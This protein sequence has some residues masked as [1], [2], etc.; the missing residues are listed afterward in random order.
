MVGA[1]THAPFYFQMPSFAESVGLL[2]SLLIYYGHPLR[3]RR[4]LHLYRPFVQAG[5]LVFDLG[6]H[7]GNHSRAFLAMGANV[8]A[9]EPQPLFARFLL[10]RFTRNPRFTLNRCAIGDAEGYVDLFLSSR[11]PTVSTATQEW[12]KEVESTQSF[13]TVRWDK[14]LSVQQRTLDSLIEEHGE[15]AFIKIDVEGGESGVLNGLSRSVHALCFEIVPPGKDNGLRCVDRL[16]ILGNY[17]F[18]WSS[19]E[20]SRL[21][22]EWCGLEEIE[23]RIR[24]LQPSDREV[25]IYARRV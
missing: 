7:V 10:R 16:N 8:L 11:T 21:Q 9:I 6:A 13:S 18:N 4:L 23:A 5:D 15:P 20:L 17:N 12:I 25:N 24:A 3:H 22:P 19:G 2:R 14:R 1:C